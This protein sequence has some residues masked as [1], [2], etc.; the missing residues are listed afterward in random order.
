VNGAKIE[1][2]GDLDRAAQQPARE[3]RFVISRGGQR[4][5]VVI[6]G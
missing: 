2:T 6:R 1:N 3:W 5:N 4:R